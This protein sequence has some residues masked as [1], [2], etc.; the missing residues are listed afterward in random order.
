MGQLIGRITGPDEA[1]TER[2]AGPDAP[3]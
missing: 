3:S 1:P 2:F